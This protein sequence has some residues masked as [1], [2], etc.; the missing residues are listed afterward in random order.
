LSRFTI[1]NRLR[2]LMAEKARKEGRKITQ[3]SV[4]HELGL[5]RYTVD[6]W[7]RNDV[8]RYDQSTIIAFCR[9]FGVE[10][11]DLLIMEELPEDEPGHNKTPLLAT[12]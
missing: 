2:E 6:S 3:T 5:A 9:Y 12:A 4:A 11:G 7:A 1:K 8:V 10:P